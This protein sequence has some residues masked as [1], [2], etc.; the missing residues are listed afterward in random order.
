MTG[1]NSIGE[2]NQI[3]EQVSNI[4]SS[5]GF[6]L[7]KW[8]SNSSE[9]LNNISANSQDSHFIVR[10]DEDK[11]LKLLGLTWNPSTDSFQFNFKDIRS[12]C[13]ITKRSILSDLSRVFAPLGFLTPVLI[14]G[15]IF[16]QQLWQLNLNWDDIL[17]IEL[18]EKWIKF[19]T[20]LAHLDEFV[21]PRHIKATGDNTF[22]LHG[23]CDVSQSAYGACIYVRSH[24]E[25]GVISVRLLCSKS[26]VASLGSTTF[27]R[28]ELCGA[29]LLTQLM[30]KVS[31]ILRMDMERCHFWTDSTIVLAWIAGSPNQWKTYVANR[32]SQIQ[33]VTNFSQWRHVTTDCNPADLVSRGVSV[34]KLLNSQLWLL[35]PT[36]LS[37][38]KN[39]LAYS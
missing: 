27:P 34:N 36:W 10:I 35:G 20:D 22:E 37:L 28:L 25:E 26:R 3:Y 11:G 29:V 12:P 17:P 30:T 23:F 7:R 14:R 18:G 19:K 2:L 5:G 16:V 21:V 15:K 9:F 13:P 38:E 24:N 8:S 33:D 39:S 31:A 1:A 4:L 32:V 6:S